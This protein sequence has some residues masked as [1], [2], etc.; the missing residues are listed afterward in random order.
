MVVGSLKTGRAAR[1]SGRSA[2]SPLVL[3]GGCATRN[4]FPRAG[5]R[6][7]AR[8]DALRAPIGNSGHARPTPLVCGRSPP[9]LLLVAGVRLAPPGS[10]LVEATFAPAQPPFMVTELLARREDNKKTNLKQKQPCVPKPKSSLRAY[11][12]M[13]P[14]RAT[15]TCDDWEKKRTRR[16]VFTHADRRPRPGRGRTRGDGPACVE[17]IQ[18]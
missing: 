12:W 13:R 9:Y 5:K 2:G 14:D 18:L 16:T 17:T 7:C 15:V 3:H 4:E 6:L 8:N 11:P 1:S 10:F